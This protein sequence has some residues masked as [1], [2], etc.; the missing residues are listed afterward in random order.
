MAD[1]YF[2][3]G[4]VRYKD[5]WVVIECSF[6]IVNY[7]KWWVE[8]LSWK[9]ISTSYHKPH[10]TV[11]A[12]KHELP[13]D[14]TNWGKHEGKIVEFKYFTTIYTDNKKQYYWLIVE[15]PMVAEIRTSLGLK[16]NLKWPLHLT[17]GFCGY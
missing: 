10:I 14:R 16:P 4:K 5:N 15:C 8:K 2:A 17:V 11:L 9:K 7:Y 13:K 12:G 6:D 1:F 3:K